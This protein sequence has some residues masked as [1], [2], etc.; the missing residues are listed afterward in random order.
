MA[1]GPLIGSL[2]GVSSMSIIFLVAGVMSVLACIP[3]LADADLAQHGAR[4]RTGRA[5]CA[6]VSRSTGR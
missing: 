3:V 1:V 6:G 4:P 5:A 2:I